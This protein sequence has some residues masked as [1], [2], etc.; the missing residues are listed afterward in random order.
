MNVFYTYLW[1]RDD[2]TPF[3]VGKGKDRRAFRKGAPI[4]ER[5][6]IQEHPNEQDAFAAEVF[7]I[8]YYG[9]KDS[10]TGCLINRTSGGEGLINPS[11]E[12]RERMSVSQTGRRHS[13]ET[14]AKIATAGLGNTYMVGRHLSEITRAKIATSLKGNMHLFGK[15]P[16]AETRAK[17]SKAGMGRCPSAE[18]RVKLSEGQRGNT[19]W[20]GKHHSAETREKMSTARRLYWTNKKTEAGG[21]YARH[22]LPSLF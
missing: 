3:Y 17:I 5:V 22:F 12:T 4:G 14:R 10:G 15:F 19:K 9:R 6:L 2:G 7:L 16:S 13:I 21:D 20:L 11:K 18:T 8:S 1:L